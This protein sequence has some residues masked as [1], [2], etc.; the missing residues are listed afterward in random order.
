MP[1]VSVT[2][3]LPFHGPKLGEEH[4]LS[5]AAVRAYL[6]AAVENRGYTGRAD[7]LAHW[8][9]KGNGSE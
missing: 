4:N 6:G 1:R 5:P 3:N 8:P 2:V 9:V 7:P